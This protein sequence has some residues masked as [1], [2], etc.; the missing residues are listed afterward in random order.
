[1]FLLIGLVLTLIPVRNAGKP[2]EPAPPS[3]MM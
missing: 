1:V 2:D 3:A